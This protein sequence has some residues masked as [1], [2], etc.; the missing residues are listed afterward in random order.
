MKNTRTVRCKGGLKVMSW[1]LVLCMLTGLVPGG[2]AQGEA[3]DTGRDIV[4]DFMLTKPDGALALTD[5][6]FA[7][8]DTAVD[9]GSAPWKY[10]SGHSA[11]NSFTYTAHTGY[12]LYM[13]NKSSGGVR[14]LIIQVPASGYYQAEA[15]AALWNQ[16][17]YASLTLVP[18]DE[19][20]N[21]N[22]QLAPISLG[23]LDMYQEGV[24]SFGNSIILEKAWIDAGYYIL[25]INL[26]RIDSTIK[27]GVID[28]IR[29]NWLDLDVEAEPPAPLAIGA[30]V[31]VPVQIA[32]PDQLESKIS[33]DLVSVSGVDGSIAAVEPEEGNRELLVTGMS[34]GTTV[35]QVTVTCGDV[36]GTVNIPITVYN[37]V[38]P[39]GETYT[40]SFYKANSGVPIKAVDSFKRT[41]AGA[42]GEYNPTRA[43]A[44]W[45]FEG[46]ADNAPFVLYTQHAYGTLM[47]VTADTSI[48]IRV[49][50]NGRYQA[51]SQNWF[52]TSGGNLSVSIQ[53]ADKTGPFADK[54]L[55]KTFDTFQ[56]TNGEYRQQTALGEVELTAGEY[57]VSYAVSKTSAAKTTQVA[58]SA[59]ILKGL[60][61]VALTVGAE[62]FVSM[63]SEETI[64]VPLELSRSDGQT[65]DYAQADVSLEWNDSGVADAVAVKSADGIALQITG[66]QEGWAKLTATVTAPDG[67]AGSCEI[68]VSVSPDVTY[69][70]MKTNPG[71]GNTDIAT[72]TDFQTPIDAGSAPWIFGGIGGSA[73]FRY[74]SANF[75]LYMQGRT[76]YSLILSV[77]KAG[78]YQPVAY[79]YAYNL[80][81][82]LTTTLTPCDASG[83]ASGAAISLGIINSN[84]QTI[85]EDLE[86]PLTT[87][88][89]E[90][91]YYLLTMELKD[92]Y[93]PGSTTGVRAAMNS[94]VL[95]GEKRASLTVSG[96]EELSVAQGRG[97]ELALTIVRSDGAALEYSKLSVSFSHEPSGIV[98]AQARPANDGLSIAV[99]GNSQGKSS[100]TVVVTDQDGAS[101]SLTLRVTVTPPAS[102]PELKL[103]AAPRAFIAR[104]AVQQL[105]LTITRSDGAAVDFSQLTFQ[106]NAEP[107]GIAAASVSANASGASLKLEGLEDGS[108]TVSRAPIRVRRRGSPM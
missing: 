75:G 108:A 94:F 52:W 103:S 85:V 33:W 83:T 14:E 15:L 61:N 53:S 56:S 25:S 6:R 80:G 99:T 13:E 29:L 47:N 12:G 77:P 31:R 58:M 105:P 57:I 37:P 79:M 27:Y 20:G 78:T 100:L 107:A 92:R 69:D 23:T 30:E 38:E 5:A 63:D 84:S 101:G 86:C 1:L 35:A 41:T 44:P 18:S 45:R 3:R 10:K 96:Q 72:F 40:Y 43:S 104:T 19:D 51:I 48:R 97:D 24:Q 64:N 17:A 76:T 49:P 32:W 50:A 67:A 42:S 73:F 90:K 82:P 46:S 22:D 65:L 89:L 66:K 81:S 60:T 87:C 34:A 93:A 91:G 74:Q 59:F 39:S 98:S 21:R 36:S 55:L 54:T 95:K 88:E 16:A 62:P 106:V 70:F 26:A 11:N 4:Y 9:A 2:A 102:K 7:T 8:F 68:A 71:S 28:A